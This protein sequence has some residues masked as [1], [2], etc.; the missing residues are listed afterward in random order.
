[1]IPELSDDFSAPQLDTAKWRPGV[2]DWPGRAPSAYSAAN[3]F[4]RG[5]ALVLH[6]NLAGPGQKYP[7]TGEPVLYQTAGITSRA[8]GT[9]GA[10][11]EARVRAGQTPFTSSFWM[12]GQYSEIDVV[13]NVGRP[14]IGRDT[15]RLMLTGT[16]FF[17]QGWAHDQTRHQEIS[18][19]KPVF[20]Y[21]TFGVWWRDSQ[22][23][24]FY[25]NGKFSYTIYFPQKYSEPMRVFFDVEAVKGYGYPSA[26]QFAPF[27]GE[28][29]D[30]LVDYI[31]AYSLVGTGCG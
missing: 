2:L 5:G 27:Q 7:G 3:L 6:S 28:K 10:Y 13:E 29:S 14:V 12:Q 24:D 19:P 21:N 11:Y 18:L 9:S 1:M 23:A 30:M 16:H 17:K 8:M 4:V 31:R 15:S 20:E 25:S 22:R 26:T